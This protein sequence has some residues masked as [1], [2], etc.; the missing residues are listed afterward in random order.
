MLSKNEPSKKQ[1]GILKYFLKHMGIEHAK[2]K[3]YANKREGFK[4]T[5]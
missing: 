5:A 1:K 2:E 3:T 4:W